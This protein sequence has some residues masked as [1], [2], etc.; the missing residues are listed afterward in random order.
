MIPDTGMMVLYYY[1][2]TAK[3]P[4]IEFYDGA[5]NK[6]LGCFVPD[7]SRG[8]YWAISQDGKYIATVSRGGPIRIWDV[9]EVMKNLLTL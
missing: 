9:A 2:Q 6:S 3:A 1:H 7:V 8:N 4:V 5:N